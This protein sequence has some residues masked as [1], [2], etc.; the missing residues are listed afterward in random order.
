MFV[1]VG[2]H[3]NLDAAIE[4]AKY[5]KQHGLASWEESPFVARSAPE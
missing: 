4:P 3:E 5:Q 1:I 2:K